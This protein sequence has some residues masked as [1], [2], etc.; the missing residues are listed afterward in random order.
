MI[1]KPEPRARTKARKRQQ[2]R[3]V[4]DAVRRQVA[5]EDGYCRF[6]A[7]QDICGPCSGASEWCH[8]FGY[9]RWR[10]RGMAPGARHVPEG[11]LMAC[12]AHHAAIDGR[13]YPRLMLETKSSLGARGALL[14]YLGHQ[15]DPRGRRI[16]GCLWTVFNVAAPSGK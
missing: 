4:I 13:A 9:E 16:T 6:S 7:Y 5:L 3:A 11:T 10:T 8:V 2:E 14:G 1:P 12:T 15:A